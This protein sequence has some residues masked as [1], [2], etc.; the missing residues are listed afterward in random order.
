MV[1]KVSTNGKPSS[2][3]GQCCLGEKVHLT[4]NVDTAADVMS[5]N[6]ISVNEDA[7]IQDAI[8]M[9]TTRGFAAAPVIHERECRLRKKS[10]R[11][12]TDA[13]ELLAPLTKDVP[14]RDRTPISEIMTPGVVTVR[15]ATLAAEVVRIMLEC[16][17]H[18][19]FVAEED[20]TL[21][22]VINVFD[23]L[24]HLG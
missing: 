2:N 24:R 22:G 23:V 13:A 18:Q 11:A 16:R 12:M 20:G 15:R 4:V 14:A 3:P 21:I 19:V 17:V 10:A 6:P 8:E 9:L 5:D 7:D 1:L